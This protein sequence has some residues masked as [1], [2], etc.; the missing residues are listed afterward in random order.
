MA[1]SLACAP[2]IYPWYLL[3]FTPFLWSRATGPLLAWTLS[4]VPVYVVWERTRHGGRWIVPFSVEAMEYGCVVAAA[5]ALALFAR[6]QAA[7]VAP[8]AELQ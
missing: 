6:R 3:Y 5:I 7:R 4:A 1:V 8:T 2:V